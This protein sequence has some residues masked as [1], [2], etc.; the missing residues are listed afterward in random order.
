MPGSSTP[1]EVFCS[2]AHENESLQLELKYHL[3]GLGAF[4]SGMIA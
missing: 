4:P 1:V 3:S 2:Y